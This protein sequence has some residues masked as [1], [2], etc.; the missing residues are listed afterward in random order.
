MI[1][2]N[3][4]VV[5]TL[6]LVFFAASIGFVIIIHKS[7]GYFCGKNIFDYNLYTGV[8]HDSFYSANSDSESG[9]ESDNTHQKTE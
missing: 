8:R 1:E 5:W 2:L 9:S 4:S 7:L 3:D 6:S